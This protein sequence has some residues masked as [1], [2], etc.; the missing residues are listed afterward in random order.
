MLSAILI[1]MLTLLLIGTLPRW[2][3]R[4]RGQGPS[5]AIGIVLVVIVIPALHHPM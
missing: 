5:G 4:R 1:V 3:C 2:G